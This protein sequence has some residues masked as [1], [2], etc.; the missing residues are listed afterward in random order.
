MD[1]DDDDDDDR[2]IRAVSSM[3]VKACAIIHEC[4]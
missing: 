3:H 4:Q 2:P 1:D